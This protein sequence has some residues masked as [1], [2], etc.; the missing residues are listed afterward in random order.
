MYYSFEH[1]HVIMEEVLENKIRSLH[2]E[3]ERL[4]TELKASEADK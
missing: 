1:A 2:R 3:V 4:K